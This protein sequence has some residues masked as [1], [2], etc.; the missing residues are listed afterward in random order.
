M[1][2]IKFDLKHGS[3]SLDSAPIAVDENGV[4]AGSIAKLCSPPIQT[5]EGR[6]Q[7][8]LSRKASVCGKSADGVIEVG[9]GRVCAVTFLFDLIGFFES[10]VLESKI[11]K[12]CEKS[13]NQNLISNHPSTAFLDSCEWGRAIFFYD[14]KQGDL[15][16]DITFQRSSNQPSLKV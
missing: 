11:L 8:R 1:H 14:V 12:A 7:Y 5:D 10:S 15:S 16:L 13:L 4:L 9:G 6:T 2:I 3:A